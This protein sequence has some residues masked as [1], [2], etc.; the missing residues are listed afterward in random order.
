MQKIKSTT[1]SFYA[2]IAIPRI[3]EKQPLSYEEQIATSF[4]LAMTVFKRLFNISN[5]LSFT[6]PHTMFGQNLRS[7]LFGLTPLLRNFIII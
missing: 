6:L 3:R 4:L 5:V 1:S 2:V 7:F